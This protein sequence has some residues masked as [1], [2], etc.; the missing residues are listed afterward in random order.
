MTPRISTVQNVDLS[1]KHATQ[2]A[3]SGPQLVGT[4]RHSRMVWPIGP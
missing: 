1:P 2:L 3:A 4:T